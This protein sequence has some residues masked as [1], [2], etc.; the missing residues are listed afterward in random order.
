MKKSLMTSNIF[1]YRMVTTNDLTD[2]PGNHLY[3]IECCGKCAVDKVYNKNLAANDGEKFFISSVPPITVSNDVESQD[4]FSAIKDRFP[5]I[6]L[7]RKL[8]IIG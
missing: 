8:R 6:Q 7:A 3:S 5:G 1:L 2:P 4:M